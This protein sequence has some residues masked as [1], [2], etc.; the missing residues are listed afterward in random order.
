[1][2]T[3]LFISRDDLTN[4]TILDGNIDTSKFIQFIKIAQQIH[5][6]NYL[7][8]ALYDSIS[9]KIIAN[10]LTGDYLLLVDKY[11]KPMLIHYA[12][13]DYLPFASYQISNGGVYKHRSEN[14]DSATPQEVDKM[15]DRHRQFAQFYTRRYLDYMFIIQ[16][17][18]QSIIIMMLT[19]CGQTILRTLQVGCYNVWTLR[20]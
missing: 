7:G 6:Q 10:Q 9:D 1:M 18:I 2:A 17:Y 15:I 20:K 14:S 8:T 5:L 19:A 11:L 12:M 4:N 13:V 3:A 16:T